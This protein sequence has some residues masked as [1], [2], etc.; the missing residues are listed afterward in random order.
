MFWKK[1]RLSD[2]SIVSICLTVALTHT[3]AHT[4]STSASQEFA[5]QTH[6]STS[7]W[8]EI[9]QS[10]SQSCSGYS[11]AVLLT[12]GPCVQ[13]WGD[14]LLLHFSIS[15]LIS[16]ADKAPM[17][18]LPLLRPIVIVE[19]LPLTSCPTPHPPS[20]I[21]CFLHKVRL[22]PST[23]PL[24][25]ETDQLLAFFAVILIFPSSPTTFAYFT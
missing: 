10:G 15:P 4:H 5:Y 14:F 25:P 21:C 23:Q 11:D 24:Y 22:V 7:Y 9:V 18:S 6:I 13:V 2:C 17:Q 16:P 12:E 3:H 1:S 19:I 20:L 8:P